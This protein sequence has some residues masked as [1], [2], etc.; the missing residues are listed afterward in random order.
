M[1]CVCNQ[2]RKNTVDSVRTKLYL[3]NGIDKGPTLTSYVK[4]KRNTVITDYIS[5]HSIADVLS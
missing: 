3:R 4:N 5:A 1:F 2:L